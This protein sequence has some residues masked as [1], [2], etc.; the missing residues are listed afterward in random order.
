MDMD[1]LKHFIDANRNDFDEFS[2][3][4]GHLERFEK[5]LS[6]RR[7]RNRW[8]YGLTGIV[9]VACVT[10]VFIVHMFSDE[11]QSSQV[12]ELEELQLFYTMQMNDRLARMETLCEEDPQVGVVELFQESHQVLRDSHLFEEEVL[13]TLPCSEEGITVITQHYYNS[14]QSLDNMLGHMEQIV[15][16]DNINE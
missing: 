2:L 12:C 4:E 11:V 14:L 9:S 13:P 10:L 15:K 8:L 5:K 3:P 16:P 6:G 7:K 1:K